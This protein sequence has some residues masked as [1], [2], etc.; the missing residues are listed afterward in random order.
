MGISSSAAKADPRVA[1]SV[2]LVLNPEECDVFV[3]VERRFPCTVV[4]EAP[5]R[6]AYTD[7][8]GEPLDRK[9]VEQFIG[10]GVFELIPPE[11]VG[12][13]RKRWGCG[14]VHVSHARARLVRKILGFDAVDATGRSPGA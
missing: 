10:L 4:Q 2:K 7:N 1:L 12:I 14:L 5:D 6:R 9:I 11:R 8:D 13:L 3:R